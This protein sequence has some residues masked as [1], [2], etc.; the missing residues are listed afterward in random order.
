LP[1]LG[2]PGTWIPSEET[3]DRVG[4][5]Y[6]RSLQR[7]DPAACDFHEILRHLRSLTPAGHP[8]KTR[9]ARDVE[10]G[11]LQDLSLDRRRYGDRVNDEP[12]IIKLTHDQA[13][14]L[15]DWLY[16]VTM[17]S[18]RLDASV[19]DRAAWS[20]L[21]TTDGTLDKT[22][23]EVFMSN[24]ADLVDAARRRLREAMGDDQPTEPEP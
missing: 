16:D 21:H 18:D 9:P 23:P 1:R 10:P 11:L 12:V 24:Y 7:V 4:R 5:R 6:V 3:A 22:L 13:L 20:P 19:L 15:S 8:I 17:R 2:D 14:V